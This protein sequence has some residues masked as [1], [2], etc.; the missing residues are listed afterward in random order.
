MHD[1]FFHGHED[2]EAMT[3]QSSYYPFPALKYVPSGVTG[4]VSVVFHRHEALPDYRISLC[5]PLSLFFSC[6]SIFVSPRR[7]R[8]NES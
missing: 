4:E 8:D 2:V 3:E 7:K 6:G 1:L 5:P